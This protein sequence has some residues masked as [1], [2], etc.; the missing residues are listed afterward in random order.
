MRA[1]ILALLLVPAL[2]RA[3]HAA[4]ISLTSTVKAGGMLIARADFIITDKKTYAHLLWD[5]YPCREQLKCQDQDKIFTLV[6]ADL[7]AGPL[8]KKLPDAL[9]AKVDIVEFTERDN[10]GLP[11]WDSVRKL[12]KMKA[13][14][15]KK[16]SLWRLEKLNKEPLAQ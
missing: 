5:A 14:R 16:G 2:S 1:L 15:D 12:Q 11:K 6:V 3:G 7:L 9:K 4:P 8:A 13:T 10:Y